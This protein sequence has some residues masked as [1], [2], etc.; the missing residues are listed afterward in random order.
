MSIER[1]IRLLSGGLRT[2]PDPKA[3]PNGNGVLA[4]GKCGICDWPVPKTNGNQFYCSEP[5]RQ[6]AFEWHQQHEQPPDD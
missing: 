5:C 4:D 2:A 6:A 3:N 1:R